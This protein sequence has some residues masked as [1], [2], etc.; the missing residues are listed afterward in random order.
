MHPYFRSINGRVLRPG[1][2]MRNLWLGLALLP[3]LAAAGVDAWMHERGR[4]VP[5]VEQWLHAGLAAG[6]AS[7]LGAV[8]AGRPGL[9]FAALGAFLILLVWDELGFHGAIARNERRVHA[10][11]WVALSAF[12]A[13]W[14]MVDLR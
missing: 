4:R 6:M 14:W 8:F 9:A 10:L 1:G 13:V 5:R 7:F 11:S 12:V 2:A 3:Y